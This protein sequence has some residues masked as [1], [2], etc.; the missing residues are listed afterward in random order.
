MGTAIKGL[1]VGAK[2]A[3]RINASQQSVHLACGFCGIYYLV[4]PTIES[5]L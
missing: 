1:F 4:L 3:F 5:D 2:Y